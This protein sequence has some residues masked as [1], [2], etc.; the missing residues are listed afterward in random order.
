MVAETKPY[1]ATGPSTFKY[2]CVGMIQFMYLLLLK[3]QQR[4]TVTISG[5]FCA[6]TLQSFCFQWPSVT[7]SYGSLNMGH[8][9]TSEQIH[10]LSLV[11]DENS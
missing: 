5:V 10:C 3:T 11:W 1:Q 4:A 6:H 9:V 2:D 8:N 7:V